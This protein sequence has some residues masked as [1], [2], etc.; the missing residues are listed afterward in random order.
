MQALLLDL[1]IVLAQTAA[2][3]ANEEH[4]NILRMRMTSDEI[5]AVQFNL[6]FLSDHDYLVR[7]RFRRIDVARL[8]DMI[9]FR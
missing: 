8:S 1:S 9:N 7:Y 6:N 5:L 3:K 2:N 4:G